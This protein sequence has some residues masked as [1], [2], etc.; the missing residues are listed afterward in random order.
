MGDIKVI[1]ENYYVPARFRNT[2]QSISNELTK[3]Y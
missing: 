2:S 1:K 3:V